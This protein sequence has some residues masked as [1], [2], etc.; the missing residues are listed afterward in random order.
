MDE[1]V[2]GGGGGGGDSGSGGVLK[3]RKQVIVKVACLECH[4]KKIK[5]KPEHKGRVVKGKAS[6]KKMDEQVGALFFPF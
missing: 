5:C 1:Q 3:K 2:G 4:H 6:R